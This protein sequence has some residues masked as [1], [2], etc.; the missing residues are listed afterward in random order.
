MKFTF[1]MYDFSSKKWF[2]KAV[3][4]A[5]SSVNESLK[6]ICK[7]VVI[8]NLCAEFQDINSD[9]ILVMQNKYE[10]GETFFSI[11]FNTSKWNN[12]KSAVSDCE[13]QL[14]SA[15]FCLLQNKY[16][17]EYAEQITNI[18]PIKYDSKYTLEHIKSDGLHHLY[19][20]IN[21]K[22]SSNQFLEFEDAINKYLSK[23]KI[24]I[25]TGNSCSIVSNLPSSID[26]ATNNIEVIREVIVKIATKYNI[27]DYEFS[28]NN[29]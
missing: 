4:Q 21:D 22:L 5:S 27:N 11:R 3:R 9:T 18:S 7:D 20:Y 17:F 14:F 16:S 26:L 25:V 29:I 8:D 6:H 10:N 23:H 15:L 13:Q 2:S 24:G 28:N 19:L 12:I 1:R